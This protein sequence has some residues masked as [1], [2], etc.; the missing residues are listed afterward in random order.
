MTPAHRARIEHEYAANATGFTGTLKVPDIL[1][2]CGDAFINWRYLNED[3]PANAGKTYD[4][5]LVLPHLK[6]VIW[7]DVPALKL[8]LAGG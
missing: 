3:N 7:Q 4:A 1:D 2:R 5:S 6:E 8:V